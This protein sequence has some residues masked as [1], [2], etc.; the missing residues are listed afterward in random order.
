VTAILASPTIDLSRQVDGDVCNQYGC[1]H[2]T[3][4]QIVHLPT[5]QTASLGSPVTANPANTISLIVELKDA[6]NVSFGSLQLA[7]SASV[8][9]TFPTSGSVELSVLSGTITATIEGETKTMTT[10][11]VQTQAL[12]KTAIS[13][14]SQQIAAYLGLGEIKNHGIAQSLLASLDN[15]N[16]MTTKNNTAAKQILNAFL[17]KL[18]AFFNSGQITA[19]VRSN[20]G[21]QVAALLSALP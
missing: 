8:D 10:G 21:I 12:P 17:H 20:V 9:V 1:Y 19:A 5:G 3:N 7:P 11:Q 15:A 13:N 14:V 4:L 18:E 2:F 16:K 6:N